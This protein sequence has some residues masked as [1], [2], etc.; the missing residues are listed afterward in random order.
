MNP[1]FV[2]TSGWACYFVRTEKYHSAAQQFI[3]QFQNRGTQVVTTNYVLIEL[4][5]L[6]NSPLQTPHDRKVQIIEA[7]ENTAWVEVVHVDHALDDQAWALFKSRHD[8]RWS[9]VDCASFVVMKALRISDALTADRHFEQAGFKRLLG[10]EA[11]IR[12]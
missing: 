6:L 5:A 8:K 9:L 7:I 4:A 2:D 10:S 12:P 1:V 3:F 11:V